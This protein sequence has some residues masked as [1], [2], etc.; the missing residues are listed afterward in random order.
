MANTKCEGC[1]KQHN[2]RKAADGE[3]LVA[4]RVE[5]ASNGQ[6]C[7]EVSTCSDGQARAALRASEGRACKRAVQKGW[8][9]LDEGCRSRSRSKLRQRQPCRG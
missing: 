5:L 9:T 2:A 4:R 3:R 1:G 8:C 6:T 7:A